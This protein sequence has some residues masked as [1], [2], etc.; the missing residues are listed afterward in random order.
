[1]MLTVEAVVNVGVERVEGFRCG[2][3]GDRNGQNQDDH[4]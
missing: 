1:M 2:G 4:W 3:Q